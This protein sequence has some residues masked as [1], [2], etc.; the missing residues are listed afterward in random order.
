MDSTVV[1]LHSQKCPE[2]PGAA[3]AQPF[4][5][6]CC[7][8]DLRSTVPISLQKPPSLRKKTLLEFLKMNFFSTDFPQSR[9]MT[10]CNGMNYSAVRISRAAAVLAESPSVG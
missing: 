10:H 1:T 3:C 4:L 8:G 9:V 5:L 7:S 2:A 6:P